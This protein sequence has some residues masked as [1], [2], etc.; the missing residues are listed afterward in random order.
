MLNFS[1]TDNYKQIFIFFSNATTV[2]AHFISLASFAVV[3]SSL[4]HGDIVAEL[5]QPPLRVGGQRGRDR[6]QGSYV[7]QV[8]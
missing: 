2:E 5:C 1:Q 4:S 8:T 7:T 6:A 3:V